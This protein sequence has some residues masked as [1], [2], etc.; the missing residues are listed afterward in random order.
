MTLERHEG[1]VPFVRGEATSA[2][3]KFIDIC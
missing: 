3:A 1:M 2:G